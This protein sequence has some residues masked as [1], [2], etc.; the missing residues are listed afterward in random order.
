MKKGYL[1]VPRRS[2]SNEPYY[3]GTYTIRFV[4]YDLNAHT[5]KRYPTCRQCHKK[6]LPKL[7]CLWCRKYE[8]KTLRKQR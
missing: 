7:G 6:Y 1:A 5:Y 2:L 4:K 3:E 8:H